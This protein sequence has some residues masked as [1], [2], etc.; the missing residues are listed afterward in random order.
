MTGDCV[1]LGIDRAGRLIQYQ[2]RLRRQHRLGDHGRDDAAARD[3]A[4]RGCSSRWSRATTRT[5]R[6]CV[7]L[8][9]GPG[10]SRDHASSSSTR[11]RA[12]FDLDEADIVIC[13]GRASA[14]R[15]ASSARRRRR[16]GAAVGGDRGAAEAGS[17]RRAGRSGSPAGRSRR[18][19]MIAVET[20]GDFEHAAGIGQGRRDPRLQANER[21]RSPAR[22]RRGRRRLARDAPAFARGRARADAAPPARMGRPRRP[23]ARLPARRLRAR[24]ALPAAGRGAPRATASECSR[25]DLR[26]HGRSGWEPPW[27]IAHARRRTCSRRS[28]AGVTAP[29]WV[30]HSFGA[31]LVLELCARGGPSASSA[32]CCSTRRSA[33]C[34]TSALDFAE[35]AAVRRVLRD[36]WTRRSTR[37]SRPVAPTPRELLEEEMREHL[38]ELPDGRL[39]RYR[40]CRAAVATAYGELCTESAAADRCGP[41]AASCSP[42]HVRAR[43]RRPARAVRARA[44]RP[45]RGRRRARRA[46]RLLGRVR[47]D[48]RRARARF[49][50]R[51]SARRARS[52]PARRPASRSRSRGRGSG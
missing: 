11:G 35:D 1:G 6:G 20:E 8:P 51:G 31:R 12:G 50:P 43:P 18:G 30:G 2:A 49:C 42:T 9:V 5:A 16:L 7:E 41:D 32:P 39:L 25:L 47:G 38:V 37:G 24:P 45:A 23:A 46:H 13:A 15:W 3:R 26:G 29:T 22:R 19:S 10:R 34:R 21:R 17:C 33:S 14:R 44:R 36:A 40:Y 4:T 52:R 28:T 27:N 48:R